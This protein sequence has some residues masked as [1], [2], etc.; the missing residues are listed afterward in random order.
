VDN[1]KYTWYTQQYQMLDAQYKE[2]IQTLQ[3]SA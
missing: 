3:A 2:Q 1:A